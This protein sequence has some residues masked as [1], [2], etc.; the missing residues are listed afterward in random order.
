MRVAAVADLHGYLPDVPPCDLLL[1]GGDLCPVA[2]HDVG[3]QA[4]W[5][6]GPFR[7][8]LEAVAAGEVAAIAGNHDLVFEQA[9]DLVPRLPWTYLEDSASRVAGL[10]LWGSP[11]TPW[12]YDWAFNAPRIAGE[13]FLH[14]R[15]AAVPADVDV[16]VLHGPPAGYGDVV[17]PGRGVGSTAAL[18]LVDR[19]T[20]ALCVFGHIHEGRGEW[21]RGPTRLA[22]VAA[23]DAAYRLRP[24]PVAVFDL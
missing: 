23:V 7:A 17:P 5:L 21:R 20:P 18:E 9:P 14:E 4:D 11:W 10:E 15:Y 6:D 19:V 8:W 2:N 3:F 1:L 22:N 24:R 13:S 12:F 16:L